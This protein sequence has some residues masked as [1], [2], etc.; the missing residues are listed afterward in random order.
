MPI[1]PWSVAALGAL[2]YVVGGIPAG[3]LLVRWRSKLDIRRVGTGNIGT[4]NIYR[5]AGP[6]L[7]ALVGPLQ[8]AQ[9]LA[10]VLLARALGAPPWLWALTGICA[11]IGNGW[12]FYMGMR[13]G[14][15]VAVTTGVVAGLGIIPLAVL[16]AF[17]LLGLIAQRIAVGVLAG[18]VVLPVASY[19]SGGGDVAAGL[20]VILLV[21]LARRLEGVA[22]DLREAR[23]GKAT[24]VARRLLLDERPGQSLVGPNEGG[25]GAPQP[26]S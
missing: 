11:V 5:N 3:W 7:A 18:M 17:Y 25:A 14:R 2:G 1:T 19:A 20:V 9:G 12:P 21:V 10:P 24:L 4:A 15:G 16:L 6:A 13:G 23:R 8:F 26:H 22:Q